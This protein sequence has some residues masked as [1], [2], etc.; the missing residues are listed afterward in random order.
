MKKHFYLSILF[1]LCFVFAKAQSEK[2][3]LEQRKAEIQR[4]INQFDR[5]LKNVRKEEKTMVL[6]VE[7]IDKKILR[8]QEIINITNKQANNLTRNIKANAAE[9]KKLN[10]EVKA[11]KAEYAEM[12][13]KSY[14]SQNDQ[15][16]LMFL[17]SSEDF[18][19]AYKRVQYLKSYAD[20]RKKQAEE[21]TIKSD[22][23]AAKNVALEEEKKE[24]NKVLALNKKQRAAL[25]ID[26]V[27]QEN[28]LA[29]VKENE[30]KYAADI[31]VKAKE[32]NKIDRELKALIAA[33]IK[34]SN[35]GKT[36]AVANKFFLTPEAK[37]LAN[38]FKS[39]KGKLPWP[40]EEGFV[41]RRYGTQPHP[42]VRSLTIDSNGI[43][44]QSPGGAKVRAIFEGEVIRITKSKYGILA[45]HIRHGN[46]TSIYD[47]L[48]SVSVE[49]GDM[50]NTKDI[51]GEIFTSNSGE[52][53]LKF[54]LM[55][56]NDTVD[57]A[58]W[59]ARK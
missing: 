36:G 23:I 51:I 30:K 11:L 16:R 40:V 25:K 58:Q 31:K 5:L 3:A 44:L 26:K 19:Q 20:Y 4:E 24:K 32:R 41:S 21:I 53:E 50:V 59:I 9:I 27:E 29:V 6:L 33:D 57:P 39:N 43:R 22:A 10:T 15:S 13:V 7:T 14:K 37:I 34:A 42:V 18:L 38:N 48:K 8:T 46:Y 56:D 49:K 52:T 28:L 17:L 54:V 55:Q 45:V 47:N 2:A 35:K 1:L 12:I